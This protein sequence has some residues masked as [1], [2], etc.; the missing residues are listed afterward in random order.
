MLN[1]RN[2]FSKLFKLASIVQNVANVYSLI[3]NNNE[4]WFKRSLIVLYCT[5]ITRNFQNFQTWFPLQ[6]NPRANKFYSTFYV[7]VLPWEIIS[8]LF[9]NTTHK[10]IFVQRNIEETSSSDETKGIEFTRRK[11]CSRVKGI[12]WKG[13][14]V[15]QLASRR[16]GASSIDH[17]PRNFAT[18]LYINF[19][20]FFFEETII[21]LTIFLTISLRRDSSRRDI[22]VALL[23]G[24]R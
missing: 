8:R 21:F 15:H 9:L 16:V 20:N 23:L 12:L 1:V 4:R 11:N 14:C 2:L 7:L 5:N 18:K 17:H 6:T 10:R 13:N 24:N 22:S 3:I 19:N